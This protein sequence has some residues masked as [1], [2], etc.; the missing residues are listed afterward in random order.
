MGIL[1]ANM[2]HEV[3][4]RP[5]TNHDTENI[6]ALV[7]SILCEYHLQ[8]DLETSDSDLTDL[9]ATYTDSGG[10]FSVVEDSTG[11]MLGVFALQNLDDETCKLRKM[12]L[13]PQARGFGLG[14]KMLERAIDA[15]REHGFK[16][17]V[18]ETTSSMTDAISLYTRAGFRLVNQRAFSPGCDR[19]YSL[20]LAGTGI[21]SSQTT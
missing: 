13:R 11:N 7:R 9:E 5:A 2:N 4:I 8:L 1:T 21:S 19:V 16:E 12:Y 10:F 3:T 17:I 6:I 15:A 18:L 20:C 14:N